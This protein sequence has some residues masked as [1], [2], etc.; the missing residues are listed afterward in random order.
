MS[1][2]T[3]GD[4]LTKW[5]E[6][7]KMKL[8][9]GFFRD[10]RGE[11]GERVAEYAYRNEEGLGV[12]KR[13]FLVRG[14]NSVAKRALEEIAKAEGA[15]AGVIA[16]NGVKTYITKGEFTPLAQKTIQA[17]KSSKPLIDTGALRQNVQF[18]VIK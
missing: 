17:K 7:R 4:A 5:V 6:A 13:P 3:I 16:T 9:V 2:S 18:R 15:K 14:I 11:N 8:E 12:P 1:E 10:A